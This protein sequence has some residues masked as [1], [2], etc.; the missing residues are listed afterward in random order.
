MTKDQLIAYLPTAS[1]KEL[2]EN[3][4]AG[5]GDSMTFRYHAS[6]QELQRRNNQWPFRLSVLAVAIS[7]L[8][9]GASLFAL[10]K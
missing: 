3:I 8:S 9:V 5:P 1:E 10:V 4:A 2:I 6:L 7:A